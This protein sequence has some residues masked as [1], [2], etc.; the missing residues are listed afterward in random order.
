MVVFYW[1]A[2][3][4]TG[5]RYSE[6][7]EEKEVVEATVGIMRA[8]LA[9]QIELINAQQGK[10]KRVSELETSLSTLQ[11]TTTDMLKQE[12]S[13][14]PLVKHTTIKAFAE[15]EHY[16]TIIGGM[17]ETPEWR[18][19]MYQL[20]QTALRAVKGG[21]TPEEKVQAI[22][23]IEGFDIVNAQAEK[24]RALTE[25]IKMNGVQHVTEEISLS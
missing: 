13:N 11:K 10:L 16:V 24:Y 6:A 8:Q 1:I 3:L 17:S 5:G 12:R 7:V 21:G 14:K 9:K 20:E 18:F 4:L 25:A 15:D 23:W 2:D 19:F 22:G